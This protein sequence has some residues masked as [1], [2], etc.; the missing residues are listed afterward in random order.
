MMATE[1]AGP[2]LTRRPAFP[3]VAV[4]FGDPRL[5]DPSKIDGC[6]SPSDFEAIHRL[7]TALQE[8]AGYRFTYLDNHT[9]MLTDL[10]AAPP[11]FVLNFCDTGYRNEA[12][13]ELHV[14]ALLEM[15][16]IPYSGAG[17]TCLGVCY[18]LTLRGVRQ[19]R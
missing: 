7:K 15:L 3:N 13:H 2:L 14:P 16:E 18:D 9:T 19:G 11:S 6:F 5:P 12:L 17:P 8:L 1:T 4:I 10:L